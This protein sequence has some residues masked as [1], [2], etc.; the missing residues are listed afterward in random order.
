[1]RRCAAQRLESLRATTLGLDAATVRLGTEACPIYRPDIDGVAYYEIELLGG[2]SAPVQ[3]IT[4]RAAALRLFDREHQTPL[5]AGRPPQMGPGLGFLI[6]SAGP[7]DFPIPHW[8]LQGLPPSRILD[9]LAGGQKGRIA[10][11]LKLDA[12]SY[13]GED[14]QGERIA[15]LGDLPRLLGGLPHDLRRQRQGIS[16]VTARPPSDSTE[17]HPTGEHRVERTGPEPPK[18]ESIEVRSWQ[19]LKARYADAFGPFLDDLRR[20]AG[21]AWQIDNLVAEFGEGIVVGETHTVA[22]LDDR[23]KIDTHGAAMGSVEIRLLERA[24]GGAAVEIRAIKLPPSPRADL[25][26][27]IT[28][29]GGETERLRFFVL[30]RDIPSNPPAARRPWVEGAQ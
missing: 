17:E 12:L 23:A 25:E 13:V 8:S 9:Q 27:T 6:A 24:P 14:E 18:L 7:H 15:T 26:L 16:S 29:A 21:E 20:R 10:R 2:S 30:S 28:Y 5:G 1:V 11:V 4:P 19:E 3:L 22:L